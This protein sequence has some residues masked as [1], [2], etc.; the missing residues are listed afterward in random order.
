MGKNDEQNTCKDQ[1]EKT[2]KDRVNGLQSFI[3]KIEKENQQPK[4]RKEKL[5]WRQIYLVKRGITITKK[6]KY[7]VNE[8]EIDDC[9]SGMFFVFTGELK[10]FTRKD[11]ETLVKLFGR[12][13][14]PITAFKRFLN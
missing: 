11:A 1:L 4:E 3:D 10:S 6:S 12:Y 14:A 9:F 7:D 5:T 2:L 8:I 13:S